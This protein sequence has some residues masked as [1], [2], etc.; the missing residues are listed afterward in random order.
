MIGS[1][2]IKVY[3]ISMA[4]LTDDDI[5][6]SFSSVE[7]AKNV[8]DYSICLY[9]SSHVDQL[10]SDQEGSNVAV[11]A[12][13]A[14]CATVLPKF[15]RALQDLTESRGPSLT[16]NESIA[17]SVLRLNMLNSYISFLAEFLPLTHRL[18]WNCFKE[19]M[20]EMVSLGEKITAFTLANGG[21]TTSFCLDMGIIIP[22]YT[23]ASKCRYSIIRQKAI[24][25]LRSIPRQE[26]LWN[27][28]LVARV[29]ERIM[30]IEESVSE[31]A[32]H[33]LDKASVHP[34]FELDARGGRLRYVGQE[35][36]TI[37]DELFS[38]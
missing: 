3:D 11:Q 23:V 26:G 19:E 34:I 15:F 14:L 13:I 35:D 38:W 7:E 31:D 22:L 5:P 2:K 21:R 9:T 30:E 32:E 25:L 27:S 6:L 12:H 20:E 24:A 17:I 28:R 10:D 29:A 4:R 1:E 16:P 8:Y 18:P 33:R 36:V 37:I